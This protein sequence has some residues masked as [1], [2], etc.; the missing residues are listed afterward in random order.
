[1]SDASTWRLTLPSV[2]TDRFHASLPRNASNDSGA[3]KVEP[4]SSASGCFASGAFAALA[5]VGKGQRVAF[6]LCRRRFSHRETNL[7]LAR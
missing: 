3:L 4:K 2:A 6:A 1:M 5:V 7:A